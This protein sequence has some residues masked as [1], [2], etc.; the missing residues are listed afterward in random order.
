MR[1][2]LVAAPLLIAGIPAWM[3]RAALAPGVAAGPAPLAEKPEPAPIPLAAEILG[4][5][6]SLE[7]KPQ[8]A[9]TPWVLPH[10]DLVVMPQ[11]LAP[12]PSFGQGA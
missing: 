6:G 2:T 12:V 4:Y 3:W 5:V 8:A 10:D 9:A 11:G 1:L 7:P